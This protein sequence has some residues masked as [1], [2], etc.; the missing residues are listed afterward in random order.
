MTGMPEKLAQ[1]TTATPARRALLLTLLIFLAP[2]LIGSGLYLFGWRPATTNNHGELIVPPRPL[3]IAD[4]GV[5]PRDRV[6]GK[7]L[8]LVAADAPCDSACVALAEQSRAIQVSLNRDMGRLARIVL[9]DAP[10]PALQELQHR[11]PD[12]LVARLPASW[13]PALQPGNRHRVFVVDPA[14]NLMMQYAP[15]AE[16]KGIRADLE[17]LLKHSWIG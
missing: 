17:R 15:E 2:V 7:W 14:G 10:T 16:A 8:L 13:Q 12:L 4:L 6:A 1:P 5:E 3:A 11:Q 9:T